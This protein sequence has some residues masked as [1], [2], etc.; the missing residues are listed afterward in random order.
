MK[1]SVCVG[2]RGLGGWNGMKVKENLGLKE[3]CSIETD[4]IS[5]AKTTFS[6]EKFVKNK[7]ADGTN[8][9]ESRVNMG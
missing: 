2:G 7:T 5:E 9:L 8:I 6:C 3:N 1:I 4:S